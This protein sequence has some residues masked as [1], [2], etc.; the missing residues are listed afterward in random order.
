MELGRLSSAALMLSGISGVVM[1]QRVGSAL[2]LSAL[3][4]RGVAETRAGLGGTYAALGAWALVSRKPAAQTAVGVTWLGAAAV[5]LASLAVDRPRTNAAFW[6]YLAAE[7]GFG[8]TAVA[9]ARGA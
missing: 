9:S 6:G 3:S 7:V 8:V 1:P 4:A 5:R 2:D